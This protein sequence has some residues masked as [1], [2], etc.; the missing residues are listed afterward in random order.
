MLARYRFYNFDILRYLTASLARIDLLKEVFR[1]YRLINK[2]TSKRHFNFL[3]F[4]NIVYL[5]ETIQLLNLIDNY[6]T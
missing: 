5:I 6:I 1:E 2:N 3:K 4:Y